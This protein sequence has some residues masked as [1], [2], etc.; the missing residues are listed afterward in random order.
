MFFREQHVNVLVRP[1]IYKKLSL[2]Q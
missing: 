2:E 1:D